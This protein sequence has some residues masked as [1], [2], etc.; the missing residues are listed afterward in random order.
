MPI[1]GLLAPVSYPICGNF[2][3]IIYSNIRNVHTIVMIIF[4]CN[5]VE[6]RKMSVIIRPKIA[7]KHSPTYTHTHSIFTKCLPYSKTISNQYLCTFLK[8]IENKKNGRIFF[9]YFKR[10]KS[11]FYIYSSV[12]I[13]I[14]SDLYI[15]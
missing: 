2:K 14:L 15:H 11:K 12:F 10:T 1:D 6:T 13:S 3:L 7:S 5:F 8:M 4:P 9:F